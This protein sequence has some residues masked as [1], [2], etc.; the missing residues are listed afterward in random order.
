MVAEHSEEQAERRPESSGSGNG[1]N[2]CPSFKYA[3]EASQSFPGSD[4]NP[5]LHPMA[6]TRPGMRGVMKVIR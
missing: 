3:G 4:V 2:A 6:R 1:A 5:L